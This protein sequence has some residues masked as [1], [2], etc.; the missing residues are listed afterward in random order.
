MVLKTFYVRKVFET[1]F[2]AFWEHFGAKY[3]STKWQ[4]YYNVSHLFEQL[5]Q[6]N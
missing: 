2:P 5:F 6:S 3:Y 4:F 1:A